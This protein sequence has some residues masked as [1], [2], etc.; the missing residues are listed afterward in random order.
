MARTHVYRHAW[1]LYRVIEDE[2]AERAFTKFYAELTE[3]I[4]IN[5][6]LGDR[7]INILLRDVHKA[8]LNSLITQKEKAKYFLN[9]VIKPGVIIGYLEQFSAMI[10]VMISSDDSTVKNLAKQIIMCSHDDSSSSSGSS[11]SSDD[12]GM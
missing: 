2:G 6:V 4:P 10:S 11:S 5:E 12:N 3:A 1:I 7:R 9:E 8:K